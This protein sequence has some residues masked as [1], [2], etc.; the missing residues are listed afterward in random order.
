MYGRKKKDKPVKKMKE[1]SNGECQHEVP[2]TVVDNK[3]VKPKEVFGAN[4]NSKPKPKSK[5]KKSY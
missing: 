1:C 3:K 5:S 2:K 4:Y